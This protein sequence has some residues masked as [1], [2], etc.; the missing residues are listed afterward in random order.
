[1]SSEIRTPN[2]FQPISRQHQ[3]SQSVGTQRCPPR[4]AASDANTLRTSDCDIPNWRAISDGLMPALKAARTALICP[5]VSDTVATSPCRRCSVRED[6]FGTDSSAW[7]IAG[8]LPRRLA[9]S[10][11][12]V[13][14]RSSSRSV[15]C[16]TELGKSF[17]K[18]CR[19]AGADV[20]C[21]VA[22]RDVSPSDGVEKRSGVP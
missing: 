13:I 15:R 16:L 12:A 2:K 22:D 10:T 4:V 11:A 6:R 5:R 20:I 8:A 17:G 18:T 19:C 3:L 1:M 9:S 14:S 7:P 21:L